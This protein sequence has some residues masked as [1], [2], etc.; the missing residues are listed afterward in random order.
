MDAFA[1]S[2]PDNALVNYLSAQ[3]YLKAGQPAQAVQELMAAS[4][5]PAFQDYLGSFVQSTEEVYQAA[6]LSALEAKTLA[7]CGSS[8]PDLAALKDLG[9]RL[10]SLANQYRQAGDAA[11]AQAVLQLGAALGHRIA[12]PAGNDW[13]SSDHLVI[14][15]ILETKVLEAIAPA[16]PYG[17]AGQTVQGRLDELAQARQAIAEV[18]R[19]GWYGIVQSLPEPDQLAF[20]D[21]WKASGDLAALR[22]AQTRRARP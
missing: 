11:S 2:A 12:D 14:G 18:R 10:G 4:G 13:P 5:K 8:S 20:F 21:R 7:V 16:S 19:G 22:W 9:E 15:I 3:E 1:Q 6:G 17:S